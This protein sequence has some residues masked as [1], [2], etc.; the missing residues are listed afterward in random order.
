L[1]RY[2]E[3]AVAALE[4]RRRE[5]ADA[6]EQ[7]QAENDMAHAQAIGALECKATMS[8]KRLSWVRRPA[9]RCLPAILL[10]CHLMPAT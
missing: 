9:T 10:A 8:G 1:R 2:N 5:E 7:R 6:A 3:V 4:A